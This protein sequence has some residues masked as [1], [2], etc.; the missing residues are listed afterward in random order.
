MR[1]HSETSYGA[2]IGNAETLVAALQNFSNY[3]PI[4]PEY[5]IDS[6][7]DLINTT[8]GFNNTVASKRQFYSLAVENRIQIFQ[9]GDLAIKKILS[10]IN[11]AVKA[12]FGRKSKEATNV[13]AIIAKLRGANIGVGTASTPKEEKVSQSY[14]SYN[15]KTQFFA[16]LVVNLTNFGVN[17][18]PANEA[19]KIA[20]LN[21]IYTSAVA[22]NNE[23]MN[24]FTQFAKDNATRIDSYYLVSQV[25]IGIK[26]AVKA[27]YGNTSTEYRLI[28][29][30]KI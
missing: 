12:S 11:G 14:Q 20:G 25:A 28:K 22:A 16:D 9:K 30:L 23:V 1:S 13:A 18:S 21:N 19:L 15:S 27:Q 8:K 5:S 6:Y 2:R 17:Y 24:T 26:D 10:P 7:T 3:Q 4:K 29:G